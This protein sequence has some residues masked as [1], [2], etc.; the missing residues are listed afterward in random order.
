MT[1]AED[2]VNSIFQKGVNHGT[3]KVLNYVIL[4]LIASIGLSVVTGTA[5]IHVYVLL[6]LSI[7]LLLSV[8]FFVGI[9]VDADKS[10]EEKKAASSETKSGK[11][12]RRR[13][14]RKAE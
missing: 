5:N 11:T 6:G 13:R 4:A 8:N 12:S 7:G 2:V 14:S 10:K 1:L 9:L 3:I